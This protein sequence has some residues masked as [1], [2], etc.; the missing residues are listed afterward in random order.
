MPKAAPWKPGQS[1]N[2]NGRPKGLRDKLHADFIRAI[3]DDFAK[4]G[5]AT[6]EKVRVTLPGLYIKVVADLLPQQVEVKDTTFDGLTDANL[7]LLI[8][9]ARSALGIHQQN[10]E[11]G[12]ATLN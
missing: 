12:N 9:A 7:Q 8:S 4:H 5:V 3:A 2:P 10:D 1:G 6:V 11:R